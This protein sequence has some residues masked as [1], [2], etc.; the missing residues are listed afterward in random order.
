LCIVE[1]AIGL[2]QG[3]RF[4]DWITASFAGHDEGRFRPARVRR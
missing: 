3:P 1:K 4:P 2:A